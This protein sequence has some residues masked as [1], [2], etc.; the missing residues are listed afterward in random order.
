MIFLSGKGS[1]LAGINNKH[2]CH[3]H[4]CLEE[5][6]EER[7]GREEE[8]KEDKAFLLQLLFNCMPIL[9]V[10]MEGKGGNTGWCNEQLPKTGTF[11]APVACCSY[12]PSGPRKALSLQLSEILAAKAWQLNLFPGISL[13]KKDFFFFLTPNSVP[14][15][16]GNLPCWYNTR[17]YFLVFFLYTDVD[18]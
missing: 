4:Y 7:K 13:M 15:L 10:N 11:V 12:P 9:S 3:L 17:D 1:I 2:T 14:F 5:N 8:R 16:G 6:Y 18:L